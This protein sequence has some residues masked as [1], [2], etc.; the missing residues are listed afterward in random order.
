MPFLAKDEFQEWA[1]DGTHNVWQR[2]NASGAFIGLC[3]AAG[4]LLRNLRVLRGASQMKYRI[5]TDAG[6]PHIE[7]AQADSEEEFLDLLTRLNSL[8]AQDVM[9]AAS[10]DRKEML[11]QL[12][13][14]ARR[15]TVAVAGQLQEVLSTEMLRK[16]SSFEIEK[17]S[18]QQ[19]LEET[20]KALRSK[21]TEK[22]ELQDG[23]CAVMAHQALGQV[24][25]M[26]SEA[27]SVSN[28]T[29]SSENRP[30]SLGQ[31][32]EDNRSHS[33]PSGAASPNPR[34][35][36]PLEIS[37]A[38]TASGIEDGILFPQCLGSSSDMAKMN[39]VQCR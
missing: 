15:K 13:E 20:R 39:P 18:L 14:K 35:A 4:D 29:V 9:V 19:E 1:D 17:A 8:T 24:A 26:Q 34:P 27:K 33:S 21:E 23:F 37:A 16:I 11:T 10:S 32:G 30:E 28:S 5:I 7:V 36:G 25:D 6:N 2:V 38:L 3:Y 12:V 31:S 22:Q